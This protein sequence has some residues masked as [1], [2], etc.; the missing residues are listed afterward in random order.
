MD[1]PRHLEV[2]RVGV[3]PVPAPVEPPGLEGL[4]DAGVHVPLGSTQVLG[5]VE[6]DR[7]P[8]RVQRQTEPGVVGV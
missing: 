7:Y 3:V 8:P 4:N 2:H 6:V 1:Q 5:D